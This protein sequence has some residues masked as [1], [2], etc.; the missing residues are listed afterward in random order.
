MAW[1]EKLK[2]LTDACAAGGPKRERKRKKAMGEATDGSMKFT[3]EVKLTVLD[4]VKAKM[5]LDK[6]GPVLASTAVEDWLL[7][8]LS[9]S[10][11]SGV[12]IDSIDAS[13]R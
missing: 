3:V 12:R 4:P 2:T 11:K 1:R 5:K 8:Q 6:V 9:D 13:P 10:E 7:D